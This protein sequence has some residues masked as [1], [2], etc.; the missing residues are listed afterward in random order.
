MET[1][2]G[3]GVKVTDQS[4]KRMKESEAS[5]KNVKIKGFNVELYTDMLFPELQKKDFKY[6]LPDGTE[7]KNSLFENV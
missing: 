1:L 6:D 2:K 3:M 4:K 5:I 7:L